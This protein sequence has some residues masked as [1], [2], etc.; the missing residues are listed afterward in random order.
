MSADD[1]FDMVE[2]LDIPARIVTPTCSVFTGVEGFSLLCACFWTAGDM[3]ILVMQY[4][5]AQSAISEVINQLVY[6][7]DKKW[8]HLL[9]CDQGHLLHPHNLIC[10]A[11]AIHNWG[12]STHFVFSFVWLYLLCWCHS[13]SRCS[14]PFH[15]WLHWLYYQTNLPSYILAT[16]GLEWS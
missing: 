11:D 3:Y 9:D 16:S 8:E 7:L 4:D 6:D 5:W 10:Y 14:N 15:F 2:A 13:W 1:I 12:A